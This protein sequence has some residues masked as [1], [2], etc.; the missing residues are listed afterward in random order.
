MKVNENIVPSTIEKAVELIVNSLE[1]QDI[2]IIL[3]A[4]NSYGCHFGIGRYF[5]NS[6]SLW[7]NDSPLKRDAVRTYKIAHADDIS[8][9]ILEWVF[10]KVKNI[11]F[12]PQE[13]V[14][15]FHKHWAQYGM[16][17]LKAGNWED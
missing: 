9:L 11:S 16:T 5:R 3:K 1:P 6:W 8:G 15:R 13:Y 7:E 10:C 12:N 2:E 4:Q 14:E 17:S